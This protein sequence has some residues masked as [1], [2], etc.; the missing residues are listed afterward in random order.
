MTPK[1]P[2]VECAPP[3][4]PGFNNFPDFTAVVSK[5]PQAPLVLIYLLA[6]EENHYEVTF[7]T[8]GCNILC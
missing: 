8:P 4:A 2:M 6:G 5:V 3:L 1:D 7:H